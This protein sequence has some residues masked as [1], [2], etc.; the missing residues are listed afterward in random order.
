MLR[1]IKPKTKYLFTICALAAVLVAVAGLIKFQPK[2]SD[3]SVSRGSESARNLDDTPT[4]SQSQDSTTPN[5]PA[6]PANTSPN[7]TPSSSIPE[8]TGQLLS[9]HRV[10]L[11]STSPETGPDE[12]STCQTVTGATCDIKLTGPDGSVK[13]LGA[14][15]VDAQGG[16]VFEWNAK[17]IGLSVGRW[18][19]EAVATKDGSFATSDPDYLE[20]SS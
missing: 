20:V 12:N 5:Q 18:K 1:K 14:Q 4:S 9:K 16:A 8:P 6:S 13:Y 15:S 7:S 11:S 10:S 17:N 2:K 19:V 3:G